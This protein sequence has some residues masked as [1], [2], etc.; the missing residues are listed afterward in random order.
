[1]IG[2]GGAVFAIAD[3]RFAFRD[4]ERLLLIRQS[5]IGIRQYDLGLSVEPDPEL[6]FEPDPDRKSR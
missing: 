6:R 3:C 5:A 2:R 1:V 4:A